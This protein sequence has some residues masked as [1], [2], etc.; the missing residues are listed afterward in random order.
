VYGGALAWWGRSVLARV[1]PA[2]QPWTTGQTGLLFLLVLPLSVGNVNNG[3]SN[4]LVLGLILLALAA[5][6]DERWNLAS[7]CVAAA[8]LF[9]VYPIALGLLLALAYPRRFAGRLVLALAV[10]AAAPF[11][12]QRPEYVAG[13]YARWFEH[14]RAGDRQD[15]PVISTYRDLRLLFRVWLVP[16]SFQAY[17]A[18][19]LGAAAVCAAVCFRCQRPGGKR[20]ALDRPELLLLILALSCCWMTV[21]GVAAESATYVLLAPALASLLLQV[22]RESGPRWAAGMVTTSYGLLAVAQIVN[23]FPFGKRWHS[24]GPQPLAGLIFF[25]YLLMR[26]SFRADPAANRQP[27]GWERCS[28][29][30]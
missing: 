19:Q 6:A 16:L 29:A 12:F 18:L 3:Q 1:R 15:M 27:E 23:W 28:R 13:Q 14:L 10:G 24:Y 2:L 26:V 17:L 8:C 5:V 9:K 4:I 21:F 7:V 25:G 20:E 22:R 11:L 30:A